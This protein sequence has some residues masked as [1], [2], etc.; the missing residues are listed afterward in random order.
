MVRSRCNFVDVGCDEKFLETLLHLN[1]NCAPI[2][3]PVNDLGGILL[4][5]RAGQVPLDLRRQ[6]LSVE[7]EAASLPF[8]I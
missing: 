1:S 8:S 5:L 3:F 6:H 2:H 7:V 4:M